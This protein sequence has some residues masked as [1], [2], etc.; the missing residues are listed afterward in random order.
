MK[1]AKSKTAIVTGG[2]KGIGLRIA[3]IL[4]KKKYNIVICSRKQ[5]DLIKA[6]KEIK[7]YGVDCLA[8]KAD[9][10]NLKQCELVVKKCIKRFSKIDVLVNNAAIQ[11]P[12]G[13]LW[14]NNIKEWEKTIQINLTGTFYMTHLVIPQMLKQKS[15]KIINLSGGGAAYARPLFSAY[16]CSKIAILRLTETLAEE[17]KDTN[18]S[19]ISLAPGATWTSMTKEVLNKSKNVDSKKN[20]SILN[21]IKKTGGTS[22]KQHEK[23]LIFLL[24]KKAK[25][26]SGKLIHVNEIE[27]VTRKN[28]KIQ[29]ESG[30]LRRV[31]YNKNS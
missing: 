9:I 14:K 2:S 18:I 15:G 30:L 25:T 16:G 8:L 26:L 4:A 22:F 27:K 17:L 21:E 13:K 20:V 3:K 29:S 6:K 28:F 23:A 24:S 7:L 1:K 11:G 19:V 10:S 12:V 5:S 31:D